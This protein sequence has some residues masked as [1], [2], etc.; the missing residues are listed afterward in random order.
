MAQLFGADYQRKVRQRCWTPW[1]RF[2]EK[3]PVKF[4]WR[5]LIY[6]TFWG[7]VA[8]WFLYF[9]PHSEYG[10][11][12]MYWIATGIAITLWWVFSHIIF[13]AIRHPDDVIDVP[14]M[15]MSPAGKFVWDNYADLEVIVGMYK[16][17]MKEED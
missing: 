7:G 1:E 2:T 6:L 17:R 9:W 14:G 8:A 16:R 5:L 11:H 10:H 4:V 12:D 3:Y 15:F 13:G